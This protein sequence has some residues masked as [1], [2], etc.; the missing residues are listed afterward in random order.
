MLGVWT[1][2]QEHYITG[3]LSNRHAFA[4]GGQLDTTTYFSLYYFAQQEVTFLMTVPIVQYLQ[5]YTRYIIMVSY[6]TRSSAKQG[7]TNQSR[8]YRDN[9]R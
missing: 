2:L 6:T 3:F 8:D 9:D 5:I 1:V 7:A 4:G